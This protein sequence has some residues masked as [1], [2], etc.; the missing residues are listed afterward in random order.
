MGFVSI[1]QGVVFLF[2]LSLYQLLF[3]EMWFL[4]LFKFIAQ[5]DYMILFVFFNFLQ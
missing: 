2:G 3:P 4:V 1:V 5:S